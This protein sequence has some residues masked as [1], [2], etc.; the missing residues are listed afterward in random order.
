MPGSPQPN[1]TTETVFERMVSNPQWMPRRLTLSS[2]GSCP[3]VWQV[4]CTPYYLTLSIMIREL[5]PFNQELLVIIMISQH[6]S[7]VLCGGTRTRRIG[8]CSDD[9]DSSVCQMTIRAPPMR[10]W[11]G[12]EIGTL[13]SAPPKGVLVKFR[14][15]QVRPKYYVDK[16]STGECVT[17]SIG[18]FCLLSIFIRA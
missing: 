5:N 9:D 17:M 12:R 3:W 11:R 1:G 7:S 16:Y 2:I 10:T 15:S 8:M 4:L 6:N 18:G 14:D 13:M